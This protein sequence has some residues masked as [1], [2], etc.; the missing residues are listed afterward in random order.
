M[1]Q[2]RIKKVYINSENK[3][4][5]PYI[6]KNGPS[7]GKAY[8]RVAVKVEGGDVPDVWLSHNAYNPS[9]PALLLK[10]ADEVKLKIWQEGDFWNFEFPKPEDEAKDAI[11]NITLIVEDLLVRVKELEAG[12]GAA[13]GAVVREMKKDIIQE[14]L[15][16]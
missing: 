1:E 12:R 14:D 15:P 9:D 6:V 10:E 4:G 7:K 3:N 13:L 16:F 11:E 5:E 2:V 8:K